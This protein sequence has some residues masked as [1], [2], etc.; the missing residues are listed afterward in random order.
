MKRGSGEG[1]S[2]ARSQ[3]SNAVVWDVICPSFCRIK[4][5]R[6][7]ARPGAHQPRIDR[8]AA[9]PVMVPVMKRLL[10]CTH[11]TVDPA[12]RFRVIQFIPHLR[13]AGWQVSL[14][15]N[16]PARPWC[17]LTNPLRRRVR[18]RLAGM[19]ARLSR[20]RDLHD[21]AAHEVVLV[22]RDLLGI[23]LVCEKRL[24]VRNPRVVFDFDDAIYL[25]DK[26]AHVEWMCRHAAWVTAGNH[27]LADFARRFT[28]R[29]SVLPTVV[30]VERYVLAPPATAVRPVRVG[31]CGSDFSIRGTLFPYLDMLARLQA[32]LE[33][34]FI[35][36][37]KPKPAVPNCGLRWEFVEWSETAETQLGLYMDIGIMPLLDTPYQRAKCGLKLLQYMAAGIPAVA[38]PVGVNT[39]I[40]QN[41][42][43]GYLAG[44][45]AEWS[46]A[47]ATLMRSSQQRSG[48]G[49]AGRAYC[50]RQ[51]SLRR[52]VPVIV[53]ILESVAA[54]RRPDPL[55]LM[56]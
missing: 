30:D 56:A 2:G 21:A 5:A 40:V 20:A 45:E 17:P 1:A 37:S 42:K 18:D 55:R 9:L 14:R 11:S 28:D 51:Y 19:I 3:V 12:S 15:P 26:A 34:T 4:A 48:F 53:E 50:E 46:N 33:F 32:Q 44:S 39:Q 31:W 13:R 49:Q 54:G 24:L 6:A 7:T 47:I 8:T 22:N 41:G 25:G 29:L 16:R 43:T 36:I 38:S 52:W 10:A 27:Q 23:N 35:I